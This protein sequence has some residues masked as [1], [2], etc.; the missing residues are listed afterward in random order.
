MAPLKF[1][2]PSQTTR[3]TRSST[4]SRWDTMVE[5]VNIQSEREVDVDVIPSPVI[6]P[7]SP[8]L[9]EEQQVPATKEMEVETWREIGNP[10]TYQ[11]PA[12]QLGLGA[13][14]IDGWGR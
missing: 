8:T 12:Q 9:V 2:A 3:K 7:V 5:G 14:T 13:P 1:G 4:R 11:N 10:S 6:E